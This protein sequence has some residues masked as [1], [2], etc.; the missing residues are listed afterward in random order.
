MLFC[1]LSLLGMVAIGSITFE[2]TISE[3]HPG[4]NGSVVFDHGCTKK[5]QYGSNDC[6]LN[7]GE[8]YNVTYQGTMGQDITAGAKFSIEAKVLFEKVNIDCAFCG[9]NCTFSIL[10]HDVNI[11]MPDCPI[12][13]T[14]ASQTLAAFTLPATDPLP[15]NLKVQG[16][17]TANLADGSVLLKGSF[18]ADAAKVEYE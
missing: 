3:V 10:T 15:V 2:R 11:K 16:S 14:N 8:T 1:S 13:A 9:K 7:W 18:T 17:G 5:D 12:K 6:T 4:F